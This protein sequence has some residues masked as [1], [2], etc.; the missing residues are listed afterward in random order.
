MS[1]VEHHFICLLTICDNLEG[2]DRG[3]EEGRFK[4]RR[5]VYAYG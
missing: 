4:R 5:Y 3:M 1:D 2:W